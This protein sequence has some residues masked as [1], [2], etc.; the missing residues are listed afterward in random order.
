M[1]K[2]LSHSVDDK[3]V[4]KLSPTCIGTKFL[5]YAHKYTHTDKHT[6][7]KGKVWEAKISLALKSY[8]CQSKLWR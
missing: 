5:I 3:L 6:Y 2:S 7:H 4:T 1:M 8:F